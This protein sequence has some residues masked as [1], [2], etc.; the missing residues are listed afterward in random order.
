MSYARTERAALARLLTETGPDA[1]TLCE[2]WTT[3]DLVAHL[4]MRERH[5]AALG[6]SVR[7]FAGS[8]ERVRRRMTARPYPSLISTFAAGPPWWSPLRVLDRLASTVEM[9]VHHEDVRRA[10]P[11]RWSVRALPRAHERALRRLLKPAFRRLCKEIPAAQ[12]PAI[13]LEPAGSRPVRIGDGDSEPAVRIAGDVGEL[14]L[15][16]FGRQRHAKVDITGPENAAEVLRN[17]RISG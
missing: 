15:F 11:G 6:L 12:R 2:G 9:F 4:V 8:T 3:R 16:G 13:V 14:L 10:G 17:A 5:P 7:P 1:P